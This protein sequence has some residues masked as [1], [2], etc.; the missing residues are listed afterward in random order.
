MLSPPPLLY[1]I[2]WGEGADT[3][4]KPICHLLRLIL[5]TNIIFVKKKKSSDSNVIIWYVLTPYL[6][7]TTQSP[8]PSPLKPH[9]YTS[10]SSDY[11]L[12]YLSTY[13]CIWTG[14]KCTWF[15]YILHVCT[16]A[17]LGILF[18]LSLLMCSATGSE[19]QRKGW[20]GGGINLAHA[21]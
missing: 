16:N 5:N 1:F 3:N 10:P 7:P 11:P 6:K 14:C 19:N 20:W 21:S 15:F 18:F 9:V 4:N 8:L 13:F 2:I 12:V 17:K